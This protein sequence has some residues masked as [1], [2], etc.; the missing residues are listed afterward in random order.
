MDYLGIADELKKALSE[1][2]ESGGRGKTTLDK[3]EAVALML[4]KYEMTVALFHGFDYTK[5]FTAS[6]REK[7]V[8]YPCCYGFHNKAGKW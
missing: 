3:E 8:T 1:Y 6:P 4:E 5:F 7:N 2:T